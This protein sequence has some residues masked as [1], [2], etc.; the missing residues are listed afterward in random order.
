MK[1]PFFS[2]EEDTYRTVTRLYE[3]VDQNAVLYRDRPLFIYHD[4]IDTVTVTYSDFKHL[5]DRTAEGMKKLDVAGKRVA[6]IGETSVDWVLMYLATVANGGVVVPLDK[7]LSPDE[8]LKFIVKAQVSCVAY[9]SHF[10]ELFQTRASE[11]PDV[12]LFVELRSKAEETSGKQYIT[13]N[14][15]LAVGE[16][17]LVDHTYNGGYDTDPDVMCA[18][19]FTSGT[20]GSS[21]GVM[22]SQ[23]N[24]CFV[25]N[26]IVRG[27]AIRQDDILMSVLPI[28]HTY[29][30]TC[31][32]FGPMMYGACVCISDGLRYVAK[33]LKEFR[34]TVMTLV[35]LFVNQL[36]KNIWKNAEK[37]GVANTLRHALK[38]SGGL[39]FAHVDL[40]KRLFS[41]VRDGLGGRLRCIIV[42]GA[43][44]NPEMGKEFTEFGVITCQ[45]YGITEC[46]PL[47]SFVPMNKYNPQSCGLPIT[48]LEVRIDK[49]N[50]LDQC[51]EIVVRGDNVMLGYYEDPEQT[52][53][54]L[55]PDGWFRTG[56]YG[57]QDKNGYLYITGR[58]KNVIVLSGGKNVFPEEIEEYLEPLSLVEEAVVVGR[59]ADD[60]ETILI[61]A[62]IYPNMEEAQNRGLHS[63]EVLWNA[64]HEDITEINRSLPNF[65]KIQRIE[66][67]T[68]PFN[69]TTTQKI[70]R[71]DISKEE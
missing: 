50:E 11:V 37:Q 45:G 70:K 17:A 31:G 20:T 21:K 23:K 25:L 35:P 34:P 66:M 58:K 63:Q 48:D 10:S 15:L 47:I 44:L 61:T 32:I 9:S 59:T 5:L 55:S 64:I 43:A 42:G 18:I 71:Q 28:H 16:H 49:E 60:G 19:L 51:G 36:H 46:A 67:R 6:I 1:L 13:F 54:V 57:Y 30:L 41:Q 29:E 40:R 26:G 38:I 12:S 52:A 2:K 24:I 53:E 69:K 62:L 68:K 27:L 7:E 56:D 65:K 22:L 8:I 33:N 39:R 3:L 4:G 14:Q